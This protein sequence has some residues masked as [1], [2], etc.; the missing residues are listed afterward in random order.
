L[1]KPLCATEASATR[2]GCNAFLA[3]AERLEHHPDW[4]NFY[5]RV[6]VRLITHDSGKVT[7]LDLALEEVIDGQLESDL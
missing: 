1:G 2:A 3:G 6:E 4:T 5:N 7:A